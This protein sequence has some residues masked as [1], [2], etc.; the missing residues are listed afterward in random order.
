[1]QDETQPTPF[2]TKQETGVSGYEVWGKRTESSDE[3]SLITFVQ[4]PTTQVDVARLPAGEPWTFKMRT[5]MADGTTSDFGAELDLDLPQDDSAPPAPSTPT[6]S[7]DRAIATITWD[8]LTV[9]S[10][11]MPADFDRVS[12]WIATSTTGPW[13]IAG[14]L[15]DTGSVVFSTGDYVHTYYVYLSAWDKTGNQSPS[16]AQASFQ[17]TPLVNEQSI[18]DSLTAITGQVQTAQGKADTAF[19]SANGKNNI[20]W[21]SS[22]PTDGGKVVGD[23][24][25]VRDQTTGVVSSQ[26]N[27]D[28]SKWAQTTIGSMVIGAIDAGK[29]TTGTLA[30]ERIGANTITA[31]KIAS[32]AVTTGKLDANAVTADKIQAGA[33]TGTKI[34]ADA[35]NGK[36]ITGATIQTTDLTQAGSAGT[37]LDSTGLKITTGSAVPR[38]TYNTPQYPNIVS[39]SAAFPYVAVTNRTWA[40]NVSVYDERGTLVSK[41]TDCTYALSIGWDRQGNLYI[42]SNGYTDTKEHVWVYDTLFNKTADFNMSERSYQLFGTDNGFVSREWTFGNVG[43]QTI[44]WYS[45]TGAVTASFKVPLNMQGIF[46]AYGGRVYTRYWDTGTPAPQMRI[47]NQDGT[48]YKAVDMT[49]TDYNANIGA[50]SVNSGDGSW[51]YVNAQNQVVVRN[52]DG[53]AA[54]TFTPFTAAQRDING[55]QVATTITDTSFGY[56]GYMSVLVADT[57]SVTVFSTPPNVGPTLQSSNG[58][59]DA[60][61]LNTHGLLTADM[62]SATAIDANNL[63]TNSLTIGKNPQVNSFTFNGQNTLTHFDGTAGTRAYLTSNNGWAIQSKSSTIG[64]QFAFQA[65]QRDGSSVPWGVSFEDS[66]GQIGLIGA[67]SGINDGFG[68]VSKAAG[69]GHLYLEGAS[70]NYR[71]RSLTIANGATGSTGTALGI[72]DNGTIYHTTSARKY[73]TNIRNYP[74]SQ[75]LE[76]KLLNINP[77]AYWDKGNWERCQALK[78]AEE[79]GV[80][81]DGDPAECRR[82]DDYIGVI[83]ED[84]IEL[85]LNDF[86]YFGSEDQPENVT[87]ERMVVTVFPIL[88]KQR[89]KLAEQATSIEELESTVASQATMIQ[90]LSRRLG[91]LEAANNPTK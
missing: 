20:T 61:G 21:S 56:A 91:A 78:A 16:S 42:Q 68:V 76:D 85:G 73:K 69:G 89:T 45:P 18:K 88:K 49:Q 83:A 48:V 75:E 67:D 12:V 35:L 62:L 27:W 53:T 40:N 57:S 2:D 72:F 54:Y 6:V 86:V 32:G 70:K 43:N 24:W 33:I 8:G 26:W 63:S 84:L 58:V 25:F 87:Y 4:W 10:G 30:A 66:R 13:S 80:P 59:L 71:V 19:A 3:F 77:V 81:Y 11:L 38:I 90:E 60:Y 23:T 31:D 50:W 79:A 17:L 9:G 22:V 39:A 7:V 28:G 55:D 46:G 82:I 74:I 15:K 41:L 52:A 14:Q 1:M 65:Q 36:V 37:K 44:R 5:V 64:A 29:I 51:S 47:Y 34:S